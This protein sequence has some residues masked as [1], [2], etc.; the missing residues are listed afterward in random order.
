MVKDEAMPHSMEKT[1]KPIIAARNVRTTP[2]RAT[3][4]PDKGTVKASATA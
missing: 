1:A 4:Q 3:N 2:K